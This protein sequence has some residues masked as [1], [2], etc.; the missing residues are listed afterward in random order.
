V[1]KMVDNSF[2]EEQKGQS[3]VKTTIVAKYFDVWAHVMVSTQKN[4][5]QRLQKIAYI[6][7]FA[8]PGRYK[9]GT[10]S[11][12]VKILTNAIK[13][14]DLRERLVAIFNDNN[15]KH[16][17]ALE[18]TIAKI[19]GIDRLK[20]KP[21]VYNKEVDKEIV[22]IFRSTKPIP[23]LFF[24]DPWDYK[25]L[26]RQLINSVL[27]D[28]GCETIFFFN[29][30]RI[31]PAIDNDAVI[32]HMHALFGKERLQAVRNKLRKNHPSQRES[33]IVD[34]LCRA[35]KAYGSRYVLH[36]RFKND[37][38]DRTSHYLFFVSKNFRGYDIMKGIMA[39]K[40][41]SYT[42]G[43]PSFEYN[44]VALSSTQGLLPHIF[45]P[46]DDLKK[47]LL[48][49]FRGRTLTMQKIYEEHT[50]G[51]LYIKKNYKDALHALYDGGSIAAISRQ[52]KTP[53][54][55]FGDEIKVT[56]Q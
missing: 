31:N 34:E 56:F 16:S 38:G 32:E 14:T 2:F 51:T 49:K 42:Q 29:Y 55:I 7:I 15:K 13:K 12:P 24:F 26:S 53:R 5:P 37:R 52:G 8:G 21:R 25:G 46:L 22:K 23:S 43:V 50:V 41:T 30:N 45:R 11:T 40:S 44:P 19:H 27:Q 33:F 39:E 17:N 4:N 20:Y 48:N 10:Q 28:W 36:F 35:L 6:D 9:Y 47:D 54:Q 3:L 1:G 18:N